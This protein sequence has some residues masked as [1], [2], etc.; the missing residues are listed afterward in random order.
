MDKNLWETKKRLS[1]IKIGVFFL[2]GLSLLFITLISIKDFSLFKPGYKIKVIFD[3]A[4]G[5]K[6]ASPVRFCGVDVGEVQGVAILNSVGGPRIQAEVNIREKIKIPQG[7]YFFI[8]SLSLFGEKYLE[9]TP[10]EQFSGYIKEGETVQ[11]VSPIPLFRLFSSFNKTMDEL[12]TFVREGEIKESL[13]NTVRNFE[14][15]SLEVK[16]I[17]LD[18]RNEKGVLGKLFYDDSLYRETEEFILD[19][20]KHPWKLLHKPREQRR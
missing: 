13:G 3:F 18:V 16:K 4:E 6:R 7:S 17:I 9:I 14:D 1:Y 20:K 11:G 12:R 10:P 8:N 5:M 19:I 2:A 15:I